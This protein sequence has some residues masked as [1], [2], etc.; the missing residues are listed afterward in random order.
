MALLEK[1]T[2]ENLV[3]LVAGVLL[4]NGLVNTP[5]LGAVFQKYP[6]II[7]GLA[8]LLLMFKDKIAS[9]IGR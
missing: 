6:L 2:A 1:N 8:I 9:T 3:V 4:F 7:V 5:Y